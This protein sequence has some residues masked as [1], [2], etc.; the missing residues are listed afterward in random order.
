MSSGVRLAAA[1][2]LICG[3]TLGGYMAMTSDSG[4]SLPT[5]APSPKI[6]APYK[7][8]SMSRSQSAPRSA[9]EQV[10]AHETLGGSSS[11][12]AT[13]SPSFSVNNASQASPSIGLLGAPTIPSGG[14]AGAGGGGGSAGMS[15]GGVTTLAMASSRGGSSSSP[16]RSMSRLSGGPTGGKA[17][18]GDL[19]VYEGDAP[20]IIIGAENSSMDNPIIVSY[21]Q[22]IPIGSN[23][24]PLLFFTILFICYKRKNMLK[25]ISHITSRSKRTSAC[26]LAM[27]TMLAFFSTRAWAKVQTVNGKAY[28]VVYM[29]SAGAGNKSGDDAANAVSG[30]ANAYKKLSKTGGTYEDDW[31]YNI[32]VVVGEMALTIYDTNTNNGVPATIT[33][34]W[35]WD[36]DENAAASQIASGGKIKLASNQRLYRIGSDTRFKNVYFHSSNTQARLC[37]FL[38]NTTF[39]TGCI[40]DQMS[41]L[42]TNM[43]AMDQTTHMAPMFHLMLFSDEN[44]FTQTTSPVSAPW[45]QTEPMTLTIKSGRFGRILCT[46]IAGTNVETQTKRR[47]VV[48]TPDMPLMAKIVVDIDSSNDASGYNPYGYKDDIAFLCAGTTQGAVYADVQMDIK[49]GKIATV[50]AGSQGN[51]IPACETAK[52]PTSSYYGRTIVNVEGTTDS[53]V[54]IYRYFGGCLGRFTGGEASGECKAYFYGHSILNLI[55]GT[56]EQNVFASAGGLSGLKN[57]N[58]TYTGDNQHTSDTYIPYQG[59]SNNAYPYLGIDYNKYDASKDIV[60]VSTTLNGTP[61]VIDLAET[62]II[63]NVQGGIIKGDIYGGSYG[64]SSEMAVTS[65]PK[66]AGSLW[67]NTE[68]NISGGEIRGSVFGGGGGAVDYY[69]ASDIGSRDRA[70]WLTVATVYGNSNVNITGHPT[71]TG[72]I[73]GG[74]AGVAAEGAVG[75]DTEFLDIAKVYGNTNVIIDAD[76]DWTFTGNIY[77]GGAMGAVTGNTNVKILGGIINGNVFG[78]GKGEEGHPDKA[79]V[80]G[81][82]NVIVGEEAVR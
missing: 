64:Y 31:N 60:K 19:T 65:A 38:H 50:V 80:S 10:I 52:L 68:I 25:Y 58:T 67:G 55:H 23:L 63:T 18:G 76:D 56:I 82:T 33:G 48:G 81:D 78:G 79:K 57:P 47:Y 22:P 4:S 9:S 17:F 2:A 45:N 27:C 16:L 1:T 21:E 72:N 62:K 8:P 39:D 24:L 6:S 69:N 54:T 20:G 73:F 7:G 44:D 59:G 32:I 66:G 40:M 13:I 43:G 70:D 46:R 49:R 26:L 41:K 11:S 12:R 30:W 71:I 77:G 51:A 34:V 28:N 15:T 35:P 37:L 36:A 29:S 74:G 5:S 53:D 61:E 75:T 3:A 14:S 42:E